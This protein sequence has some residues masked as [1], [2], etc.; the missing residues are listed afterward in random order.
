[1]ACVTSFERIGYAEGTPA[2][3]AEGVLEGKRDLV[4]YLLQRRFGTIPDAL[5]QWIAAADQASMEASADRLLTA[6]NSISSLYR[7]RIAF[8][9]SGA[10]SSVGHK[11]LG[12]LLL[13]RQFVILQRAKARPVRPIRWEKLGL[14]VLADNLR[15]LPVEARSRVQGR[16]LLFSLETVLHGQREL[17]RRTWTFHLRTRFSDGT[18]LK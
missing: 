18:G 2:G 13:R 3:R 15:S 14:A 17:V 4:R 7:P 5:N 6:V 11:D 9:R 8:L 1:M 10:W 12:F 16:L